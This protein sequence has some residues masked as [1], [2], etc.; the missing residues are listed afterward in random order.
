MKIL[1]P[2]LLI[3]ML[4]CSV[5]AEAADEIVRIYVS[6][7]GSDRNPGSKEAPF[8]SPEAAKAAIARLKQRGNGAQVEMI[9]LGGTYYLSRPM[10]FNAAESGSPGRPYIIRAAAGAVVTFSAGTPLK[11]DWKRHDARIWKSVVDKSWFFEGLY[12]DQ[13]PLIRARYPNYDPAVLPFHGFA[14]DAISQERVARW[15]DPAGGYVHALHAGRW[16]GFHYRIA[17]KKPSGELL[18]EGGLQNNRPSPMHDTFR[19]VENIFEE[20]DS[21]G[22]WYLDVKTSI[23][24]YYPGQGE[25]PAKL[26]FEAARLEN[27]ITLQGTEDQPVH[28][29]WLQN[30][31]FVHTAPT[32]MKTAEPLLRSDWTIYRQAAVKI[33]GAERC[34]VVRSDFGELG[35]NAVFISNY[36]RNIAIRDNLIEN[37]GAGAVNIVGNPAAVRSP[38]FRYEDFVPED[39]MDTVPGPKTNQYPARCEV[40]D[41]LIRHI[42]LIEKQVAGVQI[43]M[44]SEISV[45][46]NTIYDV[47]RAGINIGDGTWGGHLLANNDVFSTVLETSDHG[48]FN[49]WGRDRYW[50]PDRAKM[51]SIVAKHPGWVKLD[52]VRTTVIR[53]NRFQCDHGWDVDLDDGSTN[54]EIYNNLCLSGGLKLR[55]GFY[56]RVYNNVMLNNGFHPHVWFLQSHDVF[57]NNIVMQSHQDIQLSAWGDTV[58]HNLYTRQADLDKDRQKGTDLNSMVAGDDFMDARTGDFNLRNPG[59]YAFSNFSMRDFGVRDRRL[60]QLASQ[61]EIPKLLAASHQAKGEVFEWQKSTFKNIETLGEQSGAGLPSLEGVL[62]LKVNN[63]SPL[64]K[65]GM[66]AGDVIIGCNGKAVPDYPELARMIRDSHFS[67]QVKLSV[68]RNQ[69]ANEIILKL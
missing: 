11:L 25:D 21:P 42:G 54:Y 53:D 23:L 4:F 7:N 61:P 40:S 20:L 6:K 59:K 65:A 31:R 47:P 41:N 3:A 37:I 52:A 66:R 63:D 44:A 32:F 55:E 36:N 28:D 29:I 26:D 62:V 56:R 48:A 8:A 24:Y 58:D 10:V 45:L 33:E 16:G 19:F 15:K 60:K 68:F 38:S 17:G 18:L 12:A 39:Q 22:E 50:H 27:L 67:N 43:S 51:D 49:S 46:H 13:K 57:R 35:G 30:I 64:A 9:I 5:F 34:G 1:K 2:F 69:K 14:K